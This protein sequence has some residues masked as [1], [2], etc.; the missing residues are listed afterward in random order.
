MD[1]RCQGCGETKPVEQF[2]KQAHSPDGFRPRCK[3]CRKA[4]SLDWYRS[5]RRVIRRRTKRWQRDHREQYLATLRAWATKNRAR[6]QK[7]DRAY[8]RTHKEQWKRYA[9]RPDVRAKTRVHAKNTKAKRR[10]Q[11]GATVHRITASEWEAIKQQYAGRC[12][13]CHKR[14][15]LTMDHVVPLKHGGHHTKENI[16]P[17]CRK[18][19]RDKGTRSA[20]EFI[21]SL[22]QQGA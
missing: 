9:Q 2:H 8:Y 13:Y 22:A 7:M 3:V 16:V 5:N 10:A 20:M 15:R 18:C 17:A 19:N 11:M 4:E 6:K 12:A 1:K 21:A 14:K